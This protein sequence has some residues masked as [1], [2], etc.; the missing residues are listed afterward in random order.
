[1]CVY[2]NLFEKIRVGRSEF[3]L[4]FY[5]GSM[6]ETSRLLQCLIK[7]GQQNLGQGPLIRDGRMTVNTHFFLARLLLIFFVNC[8][9][10]MSL[11]YFIDR[12]RN[13]GLRKQLLGPNLKFHYI[14]SRRSFMIYIYFFFIFS[15][16]K[17]SE[18]C[19]PSPLEI[20]FRHL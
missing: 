3:L 20:V 6:G 16:K 8:H 15:T 19:S 14:I 11:L 18:S 4:F 12:R 9:Q 5:H 2:C 17:K 10:F 7:I 13:W 1:M